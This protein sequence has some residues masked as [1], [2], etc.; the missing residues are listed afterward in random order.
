MAVVRC[1][2]AAQ[3]AAP[4]QQSGGDVIFNFALA[5]QIQELRFVK[6]PIAFRKY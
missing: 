3:K 2:L 6:I 5:H 4:V 1:F